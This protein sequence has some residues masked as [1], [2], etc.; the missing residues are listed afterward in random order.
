LAI[1]LTG[2]IRFYDKKIKPSVQFILMSLFP[3][4]KEVMSL[5]GFYPHAD[6]LIFLFFMAVYIS[7]GCK[8]QIRSS[9]S[10]VT[11]LA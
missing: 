4:F 2:L 9:K 1:T 3:F 10:D 8:S 7:K 11:G 5:P 6:I